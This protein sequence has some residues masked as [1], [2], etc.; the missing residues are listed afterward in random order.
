M[1]LTFWAICFASTVVA[2]WAFSFL[3]SERNVA[4]AFTI[5]LIAFS[6]LSGLTAFFL[7]TNSF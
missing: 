1:A 3:T 5:A 7:S 2:T 6:V 4:W